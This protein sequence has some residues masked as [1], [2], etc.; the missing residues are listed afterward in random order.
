MI[1]RAIENWL[2]KTNERNYFAPFCQI[3][4]H[5]GHK[6][7]YKSSHRPMEQGKDIITIDKRGNYC[8]Y[9]LKTGN[10][11]LPKWREIR[12]EIEELIQLP[13][14]HPSI[15]KTEIQKPDN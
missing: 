1:E 11:D 5:K 12:P 2:I 7:I 9:Q 14:I 4:M 6:I 15:N 10:I 3:L 8:A 13:I